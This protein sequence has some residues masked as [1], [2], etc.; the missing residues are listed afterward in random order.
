MA[1][2]SSVVAL[3]ST[4]NLEVPI[5]QVVQV[6]GLANYIEVFYQFLIP[7]IAIIAATLI[8]YAGIRWITAAGNQSQITEARDRIISALAGLILALA[9]FVILNTINPQLTV[10]ENPVVAALEVP[11]SIQQIMDAAANQVTTASTATDATCVDTADMVSI[12][13]AMQEYNANAASIYNSNHGGSGFIDPS[14]IEPLAL[15][16]LAADLKGMTMYVNS[17]WRSYAKQQELYNCYVNC[18]ASCGGQCNQAAQP[19]CGAP[20]QTG[21]A[22]DLTWY[23][24]GSADKS[25]TSPFHTL[26]GYNNARCNGGGYNARGSVRSGKPNCSKYSTAT[27]DAIKLSQDELQKIMERLLFKRICIEWWHVELNGP[28]TVVCAPGSY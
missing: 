28:S 9:S 11:E 1:S 16:I 22:L 15:A 10:L 6:T 14:L 3:S 24:K 17:D 21:K 25:G 2:L 19:S 13:S 23:P 18:T 8:M 7:A 20:H 4:T 12:Y 5:G 26:Y 27:K